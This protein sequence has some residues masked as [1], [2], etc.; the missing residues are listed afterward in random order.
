MQDFLLQ[1][2]YTFPMNIITLGFFALAII[3][4]LVTLALMWHWKNF[5][6]E[7]GRG[8]GIFSIYMVGLAL[9]FMALFSSLS[10][11]N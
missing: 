3:S 8:A 9:L 2:W 5:M 4:I 10:G 11:L 6:P 7:S 1:I